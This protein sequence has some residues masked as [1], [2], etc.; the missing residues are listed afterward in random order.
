MAI[1]WADYVIT[2]VRFNAA[3]THIEQVK[4][5][6]HDVENSQLVNMVI[7]SRS[8]V[9]ASIGSGYTFCTATQNSNGGYSYGAEVKIVT[10]EGTKYIKTKADSSKKDNL[11]NLPTF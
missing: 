2:A 7:K 4:V 6:E 3:G 5:S 8:S 9:V 10:I 11:D 1:K